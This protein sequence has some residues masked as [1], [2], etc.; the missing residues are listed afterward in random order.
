MYGC[1][2]C[3]PWYAP[4]GFSLG[5]ICRPLVLHFHRLVDIIL[6]LSY[7]MCNLFAVLCITCISWC[8]ALNLSYQRLFSTLYNWL[9]NLKTYICILCGW[10]DFFQYNHN[11]AELKFC[12][13]TSLLWKA[14]ILELLTE[15]RRYIINNF[16]HN[17]RFMKLC[18]ID[19]SVNGQSDWVYILCEVLQPRLLY[20]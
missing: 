10:P 5:A 14:N 16:F 13:K 18:I 4:V 6:K 15:L 7:L 3:I 2:A 8:L 12:C 20:I 1:K 9:E 17:G 11:G 19:C